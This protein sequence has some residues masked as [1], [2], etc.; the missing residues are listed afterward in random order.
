M[1]GFVVL[2][3]FLGA[4]VVG[5]VSPG[6]SF[7]FVARTA[8]A[9]SRRDGLAAALGMGV[10]GVAFGA[11]AI[12]GVHALLTQASWLYLALKLAGGLYLLWMAIGLWRSAAEPIH[13][14]AD[15]AGR[16]RGGLR[17]FAAGLA[18]QLSNPK[19]VVV[20]GS[21]LAAILPA[22]PPGWMIV[23]LPPIIFAVEAGWYGIV[24]IAFSSE[25]P[26]SAYL[27]AKRWIDRVAGCVL[28]ALGL[29]LIVAAVEPV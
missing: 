22:D 19:A 25:R 28:G 12:L 14:V 23:T 21:V 4:L 16:G 26:R 5:V 9:L 18:T 29:R 3:A 15:A 6:P 13:V 27:G 8:I 11:L 7:V 2:A 17:S 20:Y 1:D 24:A 10:G